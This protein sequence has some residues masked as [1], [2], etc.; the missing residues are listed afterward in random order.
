MEERWEAQ[1]SPA[2]V[3]FGVKVKEGEDM[4]LGGAQKREMDKRDG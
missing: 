3:E 4:I 1:R 2:G